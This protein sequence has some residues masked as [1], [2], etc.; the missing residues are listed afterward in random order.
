MFLNTVVLTILILFKILTQPHLFPLAPFP[1]SH[2]IPT[3][4]Q[5]Q[6]MSISNPHNSSKIIPLSLPPPNVMPF[7]QFLFL[8]FNLFKPKVVVSFKCNLIRIQTSQKC[9]S[10][11]KLFRTNRHVGLFPLLFVVKGFTT[12]RVVLSPGLGWGHNLYRIAE[13]SLK[14]Y[15]CIYFSLYLTI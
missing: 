3:K 8:S 14:Q 13:S 5:I 11:V 6:I 1:F 2:P 15:G 4:L 7:Y 12:L 9:K 10:I